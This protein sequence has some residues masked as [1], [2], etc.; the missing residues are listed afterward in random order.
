[1]RRCGHNPT[2]IEVA[3][4]IN[5]VHDETGSLGFEV[6]QEFKFGFW[7]GFWPNFVFKDFYTIMEERSKEMDPEMGYKVSVTEEKDLFGSRN[8][9]FGCPNL[10]N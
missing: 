8:G 10:R 5:K 9:R 2:D 3:D 4:I 1:M 7:Y 6:P